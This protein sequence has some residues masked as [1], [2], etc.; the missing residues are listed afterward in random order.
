MVAIGT[1]ISVIARTLGW[2]VHASGLG[3]AGISGARVV[4]VTGKGR[5]ADTGSGSAEVVGGAHI[6]VFAHGCIVLVLAPGSRDT[7][8]VGA[9]VV[10]VAGDWHTVLAFSQ[11]TGLAHGAG[12]FVLTGKALERGADFAFARGTFAR[13][14]CADTH[15]VLRYRAGDHGLRVHGALEGQRIHVADQ[16]S[17]AQVSV[18]ESRAI[19][20]FLAIALD[21]E[22]GAYTFFAGVCHRTGVK[23]VALVQIELRLTSTLSVTD[24]VGAGVLVVAGDGK[25]DALSF[26][27]VVAHGACV[28]VDALAFALDRVLTALRA[29]ADI[30]GTRVAIV[31]KVHVLA[32]NEKGLVNVA[33]A[34]VVQAVAD[35]FSRNRGIAVGQAVGCAG[36]YS[37]A[38]PPFILDHAGR[39]KSLFNRGS[40]TGTD[41]RFGEA[42]CHWHSIDRFHFLAS[43]A[44]WTVRIQTAG[45][46][47]EAA[48]RPVVDTYVV[49]SAAS[50]ALAVAAAGFAEIRVV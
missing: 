25:S 37:G 50:D 2:G 45:A 27:T 23:V 18:L 49:N 26:F 16:R 30:V 36:P 20:I 14:C 6:A 33:I 7:D 21:R 12:V 1:H 32:F 43:K 42:L 22:A 35:L 19:G 29:G 46:A 15:A 28:A 4:I 44:P 34:V 17:V 31:A 9:W 40:S 39:G 38:S 5:A 11:F 10:V 47:A 41:A 13:D 24:V 8:I 3:V 48:F